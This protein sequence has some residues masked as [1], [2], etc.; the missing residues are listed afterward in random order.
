VFKKNV[1]GGKCGRYGWEKGYIQGLVRRPGGG[2][3]THLEKPGVDRR[4]I[5]K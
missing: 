3:I 4:I 2:G 5:L 1:M